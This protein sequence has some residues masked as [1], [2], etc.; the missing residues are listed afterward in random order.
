LKRLMPVINEI[1]TNLDAL[2]LKLKLN[3]LDLNK[4]IRMAY[5][6]I[7]EKTFKTWEN[8]YEV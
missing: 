1:A 3:T 6:L 7:Y 5:G 4:I 8:P 2:D